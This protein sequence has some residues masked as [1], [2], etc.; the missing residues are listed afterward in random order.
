MAIV[1]MRSLQATR[2]P[3]TIG[4]VRIAVKMLGERKLTAKS[5]RVLSEKEFAVIESLY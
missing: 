4:K 2:K 3:V 1:F 5:A